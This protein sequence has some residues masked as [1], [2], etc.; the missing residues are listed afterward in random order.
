MLVPLSFLFISKAP[1]VSRRTYLDTI[2][3]N[4][5][6]FKRLP[7]LVSSPDSFQDLLDLR[8]LL[9][10]ESRRFGMSMMIRMM[11]VQLPLAFRRECR[12]ELVPHQ[13][14]RLLSANVVFVRWVG[15]RGR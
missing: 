8:N 7:L 11:L 1:F 6:T 2:L 12:A 5:A 4:E 10:G 14:E 9:L 3:R 15:W 13:L